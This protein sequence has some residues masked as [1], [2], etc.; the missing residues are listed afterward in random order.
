M[1]VNARTSGTDGPA[2]ADPAPPA[3]LVIFGA[4]G[5]L[6]KRLLMPSLYNLRL[7]GLLDDKFQVVGVD[8]NERDDDKYRDTLTE[9]MQSS[10]AEKDGEFSPSG[11]DA[12]AWG[13]MRERLHYQTGDFTEPALYEA[14]K[15]RLQ[16]NCVFYLA[17][18]A[19]FFGPVIEH[20]A[21]AGLMQETWWWKSRS[22]TT[23]TAH[24]S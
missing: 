11:L 10:A 17:V 24:G 15:G 22:A 9:A 20:L 18:A 21:D 19:R 7:A 16:G 6:T 13:W 3:T 8:H 12:D 4:S 14:L 2:K 23:W 1:D 5:D